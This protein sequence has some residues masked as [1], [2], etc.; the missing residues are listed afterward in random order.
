MVAPKCAT[1]IVKT[2]TYRLYGATSPEKSP[3]V[4]QSVALLAVNGSQQP[5]SPFG[6]SR[7]LSKPPKPPGEPELPLRVVRFL[8]NNVPETARPG[9]RPPP[10]P[11]PPR[12]ELTPDPCLLPPVFLS[13]V[14]YFLFSTIF[15]TIFTHSMHLQVTISRDCSTCRSHFP[16]ARDATIFSPPQ[17]CVSVTCGSQIPPIRR[18]PWTASRGRDS[19]QGSA[20]AP[21]EP[22]RNSNAG[23]HLYCNEGG[24]SGKWS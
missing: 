17:P 22:P 13:P 10:P 16:R 1:T 6:P 5:N 11:A 21:Y 4:Q 12:E 24:S 15:S 9:Q 3:S 23:S 14:S 18:R 2:T 8:K 19:Q 7:L 20:V